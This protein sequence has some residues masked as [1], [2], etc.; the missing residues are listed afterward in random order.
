MATNEDL[1]LS[2]GADVDDADKAFED[3]ISGL[4]D[5]ADKF[6]EVGETM[7]KG[8]T[9]PLAGVGTAGL[10]MA[11]S[12]QEGTGKIQASLGVTAD[13]AKKLGA[14][15]EDVWK[16]NFGENI[17]DVGDTIVKVKQYIGDLSD[18]DLKNVTES[19]YT[20]AD[21]FDVDV[22][23]AIKTAGTLTKNFKVDA[24]HAMDLITIGFQKG[25]DYSGELLDTLNE[26]APQFSS[27]G[28]KA[29]QFLGILI[30]GAQAGAF[31]LDKVGDAVKEFNIRAQDGSKTTSDGFKMIK[32][33]AGKMA[34]AIS[35]GGEEGANAFKATVAALAAMKDPVQQNIA[36]V[37]LFGTQWEDLRG[38]VV[39][40]MADGIDSISNVEGAAKKAGDALYDNLGA[41][42]AGV[43]REFQSG[44]EPIGEILVDLAEDAIPKLS[45][46][47]K[48]ASSWFENLPDGVKKG[49]VVFGIFLAVLGPV[50]V[51]IG[52]IIEAVTVMLPVFAAIG[53]FLLGTAAEAG[54]LSAAFTALT[55]PI[56]LI[57]AAIVGL[58][59][60]FVYLWNTNEGFRNE[61]ISIWD[62]IKK[63]FIDA[64]TAIVG[65]VKPLIQDMAAFFTD[66]FGKL[67][68]FWD[69]Y[70][71]D[72]LKIAMIYWEA[73]K[74]YLSIVLS[75]II[76]VFKIAWNTIKSAVMVVWQ[77]IKFVISTVVD[78]IMGVIRVFLAILKGDLSGAWDAIKDT[79][80]N[81]FGNI[82]DFVKG[83][84]KTFYDAGKGLIDQ[85][86]N[87]IKD[88]AG[89][90]TDAIKGVAKKIRDFLPFSPA[91]VGPLSD[92]DKLDFGGPITD[93]IKGALP[94][95]QG[96]MTD[97][98][99]LPSIGAN[100]TFMAASA[101]TP[102]IIEMN[103]RQVAKGIM[104]A[105]VDEIRQKTGITFK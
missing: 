5:V 25:G 77:A 83:L 9:V 45:A 61:M 20:L 21:A 88:M 42:A 32:L 7:T 71:A 104:P 15:A 87:G 53:E 73:I 59:A 62:S 24:K 94:N 10:L 39:T 2:V 3:L 101:G 52:Q 47:I 23:D 95:V 30:A 76:T 46:A 16:N 54:F 19:A 90:A 102:F 50:L 91:K 105:V 26:Y 35:A 6:S 38:T 80:H 13:E 12:V 75:V 27:M 63:L 89:K 51:I 84:G 4:E 86:I 31:N 14:V 36:G 69:K 64:W 100:N 17:K 43:W 68:D 72:I 33:D 40:S 81:V 99:A 29:E 57:V 82:V 65:F 34:K 66:Q 93:S 49:I 1:T 37:D 67:K 22:G 103:D 56:G 97:L 8:L 74:G 79:V 44:V 96:M 55:G 85:I 70:G 18:E 98:V 92:L 11:S 41:K 78:G 28:F 48:D 58:I 60:L